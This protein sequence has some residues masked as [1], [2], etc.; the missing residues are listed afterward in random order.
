M[1]AAHRILIKD[2]AIYL[3]SEKAV[4]KFI[5]WYGVEETYYKNSVYAQALLTHLRINCGGME[6][7]DLVGLQTAMNGYYEDC[8]GVPEYI[9]KLK[10]NTYQV[11]AR[12]SSHDRPTSTHHR[13]GQC[14]RLTTLRPSQQGLATSNTMS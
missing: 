9:N 5:C 2:H 12:K 1:E 4:A 8:G 7:E 14:L 11:G 6:P 3:A 10:K 13:L